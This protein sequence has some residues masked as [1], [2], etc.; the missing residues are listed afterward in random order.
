[1][2]K[3]NEVVE[4]L[5]KLSD[6]NT[7]NVL[8]KKA[9]KAS[10]DMDDLGRSTQNTDRAS[11][12][13]TKQSSNQT[14]E[15]S[16]IATMQGGLVSVYATIAAQVFAVSA[17]FQFLKGSMEMR[18]LIE[19]QMAFG[20]TTGVAYRTLTHDIQAATGGM[21]QFKEAAQAAAIGTAAG[22]S[23]GQME[24]IGV[25]AKNTSLALGRDLTDSFNRLTRGIT[26]AEPELLDELGIIL[27][28]EPAM[29]AYANSIQKNVKD[30]T[31][32]EKSQAV[33]NEVLEQAETKFGSITK[34]MDPSAFALQRFAVAFDELMM[35]VQ[36]GTA[37][38]MIPIMEF[39]SNNVYALVGALTLFLAPILKSIL[40]DFT[41]MA[42]AAETN[43]S[44]AQQAADDAALAFERAKA[45][46]AEA[47]GQNMGPSQA[48]KDYMSKHGIKKGAGMEEGQLSKR[49]LEIRKK[50]LRDGVGFSKNMNKTELANYK[51][52]LIDQEIALSASQGKKQALLK[53]VELQFKAHTSRMVMIF[54][55]GQMQMVAFQKKAAKMMNGAMRMMGWAGILLMIIQAAIAL[56]DWVFG[57]DEAAKAEEDLATKIKERYGGLTQ[58][59]DKMIEVQD[60]GLL[61]FRGSIEQMGSAFGSVDVNKSMKEYAEALTLSDED[62]KAEAVNKVKE[63]LMK[64]GELSG[65]AGGEIKAVTDIMAT[66]GVISEATADKLS[67]LGLRMQSG[68]A[69]SKN[70]SQTA[71]ALS[72]SLRGL[73]GSAK[74]LPFASQI[75]NLRVAVNN[76]ASMLAMGDP[77]MAAQQDNVTTATSA[78]TDVQNNL[79]RQ[80]KAKKMKAA[81]D[82]F[83]KENRFTATSFDTNKNTAALEKQFGMSQREMNNIVGGATGN[84]DMAGAK[85]ELEKQVKVLEDMGTSKKMYTDQQKEELR[86]LKAMEDMQTTQKAIL[87]DQLQLQIDMASKGMSTGVAAKQ[88]QEEFKNT[89]ANLDLRQK[90]ADLATAELALTAMAKDASEEELKAA[91]FLVTQKEDM[92]TLSTAQQTQTALEV[93]F[94][95]LKVAQNHEMLLL[96]EG[97]AEAAKK[98]GQAEKKNELA[99]MTATSH[100]EV[101]LLK[102]QK[103]SH[104]EDK[105]DEMKAK[106]LLMEDQLTEFK[107]KQGFDEEEARKRTVAINALKDERL[108]TEQ[109]IT[110][111][112][113][114]QNGADIIGKENLSIDSKRMELSNKRGGGNFLGA[115]LGNITPQAVELNRLLAQHNLTRAEASKKD[116]ETGIR[117]IDILKQQ[118]IAQA[119]LN[120][121][122]EL[123]NST[124]SILQ[125][126][127]VSMFQA[128][129]DGTKSFGDAMKDVMKQVLAD[130]A[131]A[132]M[133]AAALKMLQAMGLPGL[134]ARYGGV[135]SPS[136][137]SFATGGIAS[138]PESGYMATLHGNEAVVP[139]G[140]DRSIP[141]KML[142]GGQGNIV[143]VTVNM[144]GGQSST[145]ATGDGQMQGLGRAIGGLVQQ[146]LTQEMRPG[147]LLN[148]QGTKGRT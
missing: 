14:K 107:K 101:R 113:A 141:V 115:G 108:I 9:K 112:I 105:R 29:K 125:N 18:N 102:E 72:A 46:A 114:K 43:F 68:A 15:F 74:K 132:Y 44:V 116:E 128:M 94:N 45:A 34:I 10:K 67:D 47:G 91:K 118:A 8:G 70:F 85:A 54:R 98:R 59:I 3:G 73:A 75:E 30:L 137:K 133:R 31:Q 106:Q 138:G 100:A 53:R 23:A 99:L 81:M 48:S 77:T 103:I 111:E 130:L 41:A 135:L 64:L 122:I 11:K 32:F 51:K 35:K 24:Q 49:Q 93:K 17:A 7:I 5:L 71:K 63:S 65:D 22:L 87:T 79:D 40:P 42:T 104:M 78:V 62:E 37:E 25:A 142:G 109:M 57:I 50:H 146:H 120:T 33:A 80:A 4:I 143:N 89:K 139:L 129:I 56:K 83:R 12:G 95:K 126:G 147:G 131:A 19:G 97:Q 92:V 66:Q 16:K 20:A 38:I 82:K 13:L 55:K 69:A 90:K 121:E 36:K 145:T 2:A 134:P 123:A 1:M 21:L 96:Q 127:F 119:D 26:K 144:S 140:N 52:F 6:G 110:N 60:R 27:R 124:A 61:G 136:G 117:K 148:Q 39:A 76:S 86:L 58:E 28:L 88:A 84:L